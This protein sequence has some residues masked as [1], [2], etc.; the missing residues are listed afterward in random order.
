MID[1]H[2]IEKRFNRGHVVPTT[3][4]PYTQ[5]PGGPKLTDRTLALKLFAGKHHSKAYPTREELIDFGR[6]VCGVSQPARTLQAIAKAMR[7]TLEAARIDERVPAEL[8]AKMRG[9]W[10][11]GMGYGQ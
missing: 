5:Y 2:L 9:V 3:I 7:A 4:Y 1:G 8:L 10:E 11:D 6:R